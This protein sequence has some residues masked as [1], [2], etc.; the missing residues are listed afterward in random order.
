M[1]NDRKPSRGFSRPDSEDLDDAPG[2]AIETA[3]RRS[4]PDPAE[5]NLMSPN[6]VLTLKG[7]EK[8]A[9]DQ[10]EEIR[11]FYADRGLL[12]AINKAVDAQA[13]GMAELRREVLERLDL[14]EH[15]QREENERQRLRRAAQRKESAELKKSTERAQ[16]PL[17]GL[18]GLT[19]FQQA[20]MQSGSTIAGSVMIIILAYFFPEV[21]AK[22]KPGAKAEEPPP[23]V[24]VSAAP[25]PARGQDRRA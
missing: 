10:D 8:R 2:S 25:P 7:L 21:W 13:N 23:P 19:V 14:M 5:T 6:N 22:I 17:L 3:G 11:G 9:D 20:G 18:V 4:R 1:P 16:A 24:D 12:M 15:S